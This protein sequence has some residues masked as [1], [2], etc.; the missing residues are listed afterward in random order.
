MAA[1]AAKGGLAITRVSADLLQ[2]VA[3]CTY[4]PWASTEK[5]S[6]DLA[7]LPDAYKVSQHSTSPV[8]HIEAT[9]LCVTVQHAMSP[10][11]EGARWLASAAELA[12]PTSK[13][14]CLCMEILA[15]IQIC[16]LKEQGKS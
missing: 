4:R 7:D 2:R 14:P 9:P 3:H 15:C 13:R 16:F 6:V 10:S 8:T 11:I 1:Q 5:T 12:L